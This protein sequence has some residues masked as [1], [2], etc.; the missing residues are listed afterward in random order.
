MAV[1][2][3][4]RETALYRAD[5]LCESWGQ[6]ATLDG[7]MRDPVAVLRSLSGWRGNGIGDDLRIRYEAYYVE[8]TYGYHGAVPVLLWRYGHG[9]DLRDYPFQRPGETALDAVARHGWLALLGRDIDPATAG[10]TVLSRFLAILAEKVLRDD[11]EI[12]WSFGPV[13]EDSPWIPDRIQQA[14]WVLYRRC[15]DLAAYCRWPEFKRSLSILR[16]L[17]LAVK[18]SDFDGM[19]AATDDAIKDVRGR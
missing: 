1:V 15:I 3:M 14:E 17:R 16:R 8:T 6:W 10:E 13:P 9:R 11:F 7:A 2:A 19:R 4:D 5:A 12:D 18:A